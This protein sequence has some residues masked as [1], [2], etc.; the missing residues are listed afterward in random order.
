MQQHVW[1]DLLEENVTGCFESP[2][3]QER[4]ISA[5]DRIY[6]SKA[7]VAIEGASNKMNNARAM[8][9]V[10]AAPLEFTDIFQAPDHPK[11]EEEQAFIEKA[12]LQNFVFADLK[13]SGLKT[14][15]R[16]F[17]KVCFEKNA[18][19][20]KQGETGDYFYVI[21]EGQV[22]FLVNDQPMGEPAGPGQTFGELS[23][24]YSAPRA[25]TC[26]AIESQNVLY[27]VDQT[28]FRYILHGQTQQ[29]DKVK[30]ELLQNVSF[31]KELDAL[32]L[33]KLADDLTLSSIPKGSM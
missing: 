11:T 29:A 6:L 4:R 5:V 32:D 9:N 26:I 27:R 1:R 21:K 12:I 13:P 10:F 18:K 19:I 22:D 14:M 20:I 7:M 24:L 28:T 31:L 23:P 17:E 2:H 15:I 25:A 3:I 8:Q 33:G 30:R 16:A